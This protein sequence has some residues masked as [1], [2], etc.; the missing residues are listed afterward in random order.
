MGL[1]R[2]APLSA[3]AVHR[4]IAAKREVNGLGVGTDARPTFE[5]ALGNPEGADQLV[6]ARLAERGVEPE[7]AP[8]SAQGGNPCYV[9]GG[10]PGEDLRHDSSG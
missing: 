10:E 3:G 9:A 1:S 6:A 7:E 2:Y 5:R 8:L 4:D